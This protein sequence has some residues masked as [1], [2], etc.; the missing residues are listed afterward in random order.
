LRRQLQQAVKYGGRS[1]KQ[2]YNGCIV[3]SLYSAPVRIVQ[4]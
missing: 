1:K 3:G 2:V 4:I